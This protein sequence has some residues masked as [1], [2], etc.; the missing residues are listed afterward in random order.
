MQFD[1]GIHGLW[2]DLAEYNP[3]ENMSDTMDKLSEMGY[4]TNQKMELWVKYL[5]QAIREYAYHPPTDAVIFIKEVR[6]QLKRDKNNDFDYDHDL[7]KL[8]HYLLHHAYDINDGDDDE[9]KDQPQKPTRSNND[10]NNKKESNHSFQWLKN[11]LYNA[12]ANDTVVSNGKKQVNISEVAH[13]LD[14]DELIE[15][16]YFQSI[17]I[18]NIQNIEFQHLFVNAREQLWSFKDKTR[19]KCAQ[20]IVTKVCI[21]MFNVFCFF[22]FLVL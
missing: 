21:F 20:Y 11:D 22:V 5:K 15:F 4:D 6:M 12:V 13:I 2:E 14:D 3:E 16:L 17:E 10:N 18:C 1:D 9:K 8:E 19:M 7:Y